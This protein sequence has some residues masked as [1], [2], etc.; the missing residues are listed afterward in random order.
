MTDTKHRWLLEQD[1]GGEVG[2]FPLA[3][4]ECISQALDT[5][6]AALYD[7]LDESCVWCVGETDRRIVEIRTFPDGRV[8]CYGVVSFHGVEPRITTVHGI[9][10]ALDVLAA[11]V[12]TRKQAEAVFQSFFKSKSIPPGFC[13]IAKSYLFGPST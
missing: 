11:E 12:L 7:T 1:V 6:Y 4:E 9:G 13:V 10:C 3:T 8:P 2:T 5:N